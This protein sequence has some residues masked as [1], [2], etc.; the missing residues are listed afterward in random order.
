M[1]SQLFVI[2]FIMMRFRTLCLW[3]THINFPPLVWWEIRAHQ[4]D[5]FSKY[6]SKTTKG[7]ISKPL[8]VDFNVDAIQIK[9]SYSSWCQSFTDSSHKSQPLDCCF[10]NRLWTRWSKVVWLTLQVNWHRNNGIGVPMFWKICLC[11][12]GSITTTTRG[13]RLW[14]ICNRYV[15]CISPWNYWYST[16]QTTD[17]K[18]SPDSMFW[19]QPTLPFT[20]W[21][22]F[23]IFLIYKHF[24]HLF[25]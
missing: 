21:T 19:K 1:T 25:Y 17:D 24:K 18:T 16:I 23:Q 10:H 22:N 3:I 12:L 15:H 9:E 4:L 11:I 6:C 13:F 7:T 8:R 14:F 5:N 20:T 2:V